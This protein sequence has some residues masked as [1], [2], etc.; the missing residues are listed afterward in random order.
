MHARHPFYHTIRQPYFLRKSRDYTYSPQIHS[1]T[2]AVT[3]VGGGI[4][5]GAQGAT[6]VS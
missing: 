6:V 3:V 1:G 5:Q 4:G 2:L